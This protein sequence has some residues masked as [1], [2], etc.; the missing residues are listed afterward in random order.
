MNPGFFISFFFRKSADVLLVGAD[1]YNSTAGLF[2]APKYARDNSGELIVR[3]VLNEI[4]LFHSISF[5]VPFHF[6]SRLALSYIRGEPRECTMERV[7]FS[8]PETGWTPLGP[9]FSIAV[10]TGQRKQMIQLSQP[11][12]FL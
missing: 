8:E 6:V 5:A 11:T 4:F 1:Y 7:K 9:F 3:T 12:P 2:T 10:V